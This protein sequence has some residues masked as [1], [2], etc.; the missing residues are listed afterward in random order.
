[1]NKL[2]VFTATYPYANQESFLEQEMPYLAEAF[3]EITIIPLGGAGTVMREVPAGVKVDSRLHCGRKKKVFQGLVNCWRVLPSYMID[4]YRSGA[5]RSS[6]K[7]KRWAKSMLLTSYY[8]QSKPVRELK[9]QVTHNDVFYYYWGIDYNSI[10]PFFK[11]KCKQVSRFHGDWDLWTDGGNSEPY[12]PLRDVLMKALDA[13]VTI[14]D[15]GKEFLLK[16]HPGINVST[17]RLGSPDMGR[18]KKSTDGF[19]RILSC[20][21][22]YPLK[23]VDYIY[24]CAKAF[25]QKH[26]KVIWT[27]IGDGP[28]FETTKA[29][30]LSD[31]SIQF[32]ANMVGRMSH[33]DVL[34]YYQNNCVDVFVN[35]STNEGIPVSIMEAISFDVPVVATNVGASSEVA[36]VETGILVPANPSVEQVVGAFESIVEKNLE[37]RLFWNEQYNAERNYR[38]FAAF[39]KSLAAK[40]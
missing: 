5:Y 13:E 16:Y 6:L 40:E 39:L 2:Y 20:S 38:S 14:S 21:G 19:I 12:C 4:F 17:H 26:G 30:C 7:V 33:D 28:D 1:M 36:T 3:S 32:T 11:G 27:H 29:R 22:V 37:P 23:R 34:E 9:K 10:A 25:A 24:D 8:M 15:T 31:E 35:L 18:S